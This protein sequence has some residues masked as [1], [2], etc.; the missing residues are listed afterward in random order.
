MEKRMKINKKSGDNRKPYITGEDTTVN[1]K[2]L[3]TLNLVVP[4]TVPSAVAQVPGGDLPSL[5]TSLFT[6]PSTLLIFIIELALGIGLGYFSVKALK[7]VLALA[8][9]FTI[10]VLLNVWQSQ[11]LGSN[12]RDQLNQLGLTWEKVYPVFTSLTYM[13]GLT[14]I[15]PITLGFIIGLV[16]A[17]AR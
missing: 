14:T 2:M 15:L 5:I 13:L 3:S 12:I 10:G 7:Y 11:Q 16:I 6:N 4:F 8:G 17:V 9:I 1:E